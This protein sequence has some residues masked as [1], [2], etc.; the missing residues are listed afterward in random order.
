M[1]IADQTK[2]QRVY[3]T[4]APDFDKFQADAVAFAQLAEFFAFY[5]DDLR[6]RREALRDRVDSE[7]KQ[8]VIDLAVR[9]HLVLPPMSPKKE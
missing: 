5:M 2:E 9:H 7:L 6:E 1:T 8:S 4:S 3:T